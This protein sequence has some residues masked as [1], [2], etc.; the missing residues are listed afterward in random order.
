VQPLCERTRIA[1]VASVATG[2]TYVR[3]PE[4]LGQRDRCPVGQLSPRF[5]SHRHDE[6]P[7]LGGLPRRRFGRLVGRD[8]DAGG[9]RLGAD[10]PESE[11]IAVGEETA[12]RSQNQRVD[13]EH[14]FGAV[15]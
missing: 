13:Q 1:L 9:R 15:R 5:L 4:A 6:G 12:P 2:E 7:D 10:E 8:H 11:R 3:G 14:V